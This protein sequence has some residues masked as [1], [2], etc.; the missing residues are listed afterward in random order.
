MRHLI[1]ALIC[2]HCRKCPVSWRT[3]AK[4]HKQQPI[5]RTMTP[6]SRRRGNAHGHAVSGLHTGL[7]PVRDSDGLLNHSVL[8]LKEK[9]AAVSTKHTLLLYAGRTRT[10]PGIRPLRGG[11]RSGWHAYAR[12]P[13]GMSICRDLRFPRLF[14]GYAKLGARLIFLR[15]A[16]TVATGRAHWAPMLRAR[17]IEN[18]CWITLPRRSAAAPT[19]AETTAIQ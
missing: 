6:A 15:S 18:G 17:A 11:R 1:Q 13:Q 10:V 4:K 19:E 12:G 7:T 16:F 9:Y 3:P 8:I 14:R 5:P 2:R